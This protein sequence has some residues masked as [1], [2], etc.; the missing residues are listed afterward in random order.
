MRTVI[1]CNHLIQRR[2][3]GVAIT[4]GLGLTLLLPVTILAATMDQ[5]QAK[6][7]V[8]P[9]RHARKKNPLPANT[10][11]IR[12]GHDIYLRECI[13]C[14]GEDGRG[15]GPKAAELEVPPGDLT[16]AKVQD[17]SDGALYW[18]ITKGRAPM[19]SFKTLLS[20]EQRWHV[21]NYTRTFSKQKKDVVAPPQFNAPE[22]QRKAISAIVK[23]YLAIQHS[24]VKGDLAAAKSHVKA[25][26]DASAKLQENK[27]DAF[28]REAATLWSKDTSA[29]ATQLKLMS[30]SEDLQ[31]F[32]KSFAGVSTALAKMIEHFGHTQ[33]RPL[34]LFVSK[35]QQY[36]KKPASWLQVEQQATNPY[37]GANNSSQA[38]LKRTLGSIH[39]AKR[40]GDSK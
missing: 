28:S 4:F 36:N 24:L 7:W 8:A 3:L 37:V 21:V 39:L 29:I 11:S 27:V 25:L 30:S 12:M 23:P 38:T 32:R 22:A 6:P 13:S 10:Q 35:T 33:K 9:R 14:H 1:Y 19:A 16:S 34:L 17:Q 20:D 15:K 26:T 31:T 5:A 18:K 40:K 2:Y